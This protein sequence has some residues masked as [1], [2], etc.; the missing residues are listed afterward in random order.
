M[1]IDRRESETDRRFLFPREINVVEICLVYFFAVGDR[2]NY[3]RTDFD[4]VAD[5]EIS[6]REYAAVM[7]FAFLDEYC[8]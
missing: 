2:E 6:V 8:L 7:E 1:I 5:V 4:D 3:D